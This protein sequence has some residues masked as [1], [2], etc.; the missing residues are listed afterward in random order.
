MKKF[1]LATVA[2]FI[3]ATGTQAQAQA[4]SELQQFIIL[5]TKNQLSAVKVQLER[6]RGASPTQSW[7]DAGTIMGERYNNEYGNCLAR[8][9]GDRPTIEVCTAVFNGQTEAIRGWQNEQ[10]AKY[11]PTDRDHANST[12]AE[13]P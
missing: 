11:G 6:E 2:A 10:G 5:I 4:N 7:I 12:S 13:D 1:L 9:H 3:L 8:A